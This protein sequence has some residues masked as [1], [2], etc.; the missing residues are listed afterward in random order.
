[1]AVLGTLGAPW[2]VVHLERRGKRR[3]TS[4]CWFTCPHM[5]RHSGDAGVPIAGHS[6]WAEVGAGII[7]VTYG[8]FTGMHKS[9]PVFLRR[10]K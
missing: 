6:H 2:S 5:Y 4:F 3:G 8:E 10:W 7:F 1:M 9:S